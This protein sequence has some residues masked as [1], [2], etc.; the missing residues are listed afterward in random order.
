MAGSRCAIGRVVCGLILCG[1]VWLFA[2]ASAASAA[3]VEKQGYIPMADG[4]QLEYT[5]DLPAATGQFPVA[6]VYDGYCEGAGP[7]TCNDVTAANALL[8]Q[9]FA[10]LGVS[11]R[12]TSCSTGTFDAFSNQEWSDGAA[13]V[14]WA[15][16]QSWSN[17]HVGTF[18]DSFPGITQVGVA[19]QRPPHLDAIAPWQVTTD[20]YRDV[21][22]PGGITNVGFGAFW[23]GVDQPNNSYR[24]GIQQA[25]NAGDTGCLQAQV[26]HA[27]SEPSHNIA[28]EGLQ[29]P[30]YDAF[31]Q[32][33]QPGA[34]A[35]MID[36]PTF[37]CLSWQDDEVS[38]RGSSYLS[39]LD[40][41][42][43][44]V[45]ATNGYHGMCDLSTPR[46]TDELVAFFNRFVKGESNGFEHTP[47]IQLWHD[48]TTN[49]AGD[50]VP[51]W[52]TS[53]NSYSSIP[54]KPLSLYFQPGGG[55]SLIRPHTAAQ[56]DRYGY[57][58]PNLGNEDGV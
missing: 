48:T 30:F 39:E 31:W 3:T 57:P 51:S 42:T 56:P 25:A 38:S 58:G 28:L 29:H 46:I 9:G 40:P 18:G 37:G 12:G 2:G 27:S 44:W 13:A 33:H 4:T 24:S 49:S 32:A 36:V 26:T 54:V 11:V 8:A 15:A 55:L 16:R 45:V 14:E 43:T 23:A 5:V 53:F 34:G 50:N 20:L 21:S 10:V 17:G 1:A 35:A 22:Y 19:G 7:L 47:H 41:S 6:M 52:I